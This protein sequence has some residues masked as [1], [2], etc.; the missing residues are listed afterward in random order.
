[1]TKRLLLTICAFLSIAIAAGQ[2]DTSVV[3][4]NE[5]TIYVI[6]STVKYDWSSPRSLYKSY[7]RNYKKNIFKKEPYI[8]GHAFIELSTPLSSGRIFTGMRS[9]SRAKKP[10]HKRTLWSFNTR[11]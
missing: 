2:P 3:S 9:A 4:R 8:M 1:M 10:G 11:R 7:F 6:P 5:L